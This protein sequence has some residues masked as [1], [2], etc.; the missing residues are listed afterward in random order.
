ME[1]MSVKDFEI[2][3]PKETQLIVNVTDRSL[4]NYDFSSF[5][6][7]PLQ[8]VASLTVTKKIKK[9]IFSKVSEASLVEK[10]A[11]K[12]ETE[13][14]AKLS[15]IAKQKLNSGE[16][17][18]GIR[19]KTGETYAVIKDAVTG[20]SQSFVTLDKKIVQDLGTLPQLSAIQGQLSSLSEEIE[21]LNRVVQRVEQGQYNDRFAGFFTARQLVIE[22][23]SSSDEQIKKD[24]LL[25]SVK[26]N[27]DTIGKLMFSI[28]HDALT[29][30][31]TKTKPKDAKRIDNLMQTSLGYLN[32][33]VQLNL[34]AYT[35][36]GEQQSL[37]ATLTNYHTFIEQDL[38]RKNNDGKT[39]AWLLDNGHVGDDGRIVELSNVV[40]QK[41]ENLIETY[42]TEKLEVIDNEKIESEDL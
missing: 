1:E 10:L 24:L 20:K 28:H 13:Y 42:E 25:S 14:V 40:S 26:V 36:L 33:S 8:E 39:V 17:T 7:L 3:L 23:L 19:K 29:L 2:D 31:D 41:I 38:M 15:D 16:W 22:G 30:I 5:S 18:L 37:F 21:S 34:I 9:N 32:S 12:G 35:E 6:L 11:S 4:Y 27:N